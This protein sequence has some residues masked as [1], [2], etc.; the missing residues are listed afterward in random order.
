MYPRGYLRTHH[1]SARR[2]LVMAAAGLALVAGVLPA[3]AGA[4]PG[5]T[6]TP[7]RADDVTAS[8]NLLRNGWDSSEPAM[9]PSVVPTFVQRFNA[10]VDGAVYAQPLVMMLANMKMSLVTGSYAGVPVTPMLGT[11]S[12]HF[13]NVDT[14]EI[15]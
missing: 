7:A 4:V 8:Q 6:A 3:L 10:S 9:G 2:R 13:V 11:R 1:R 15:G 5:T 14:V 12:V